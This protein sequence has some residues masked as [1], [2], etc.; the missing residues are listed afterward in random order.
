MELPVVN[1]T[2]MYTCAVYLKLIHPLKRIQIQQWP[3]M[4]QALLRLILQR[5][6][7]KQTYTW[8]TPWLASRGFPA[9]Q[10]LP[11]CMTPRPCCWTVEAGETGHWCHHL[12]MVSR[13]PSSSLLL[14]LLLLLL[15]LFSHHWRQLGQ[16]LPPRYKSRLEK[17]DVSFA[18]VFGSSLLSNMHRSN[19]WWNLMEAKQKMEA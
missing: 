10:L 14:L 8:M 2:D 18:A 17:L 4:S 12:A 6:A 3:F 1:G 19:R 11:L 13:S 9:H 15:M 7:G 5:D 16:N